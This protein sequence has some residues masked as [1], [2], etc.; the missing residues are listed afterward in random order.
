MED[1][2]KRPETREATLVQSLKVI[3][4][5]VKCIEQVQ[6]PFGVA[7]KEK[8]HSVLN[9]QSWFELPKIN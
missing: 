3:G 8:T 6:E 1:A 7:V 2:I 5:A 4:E 9:K